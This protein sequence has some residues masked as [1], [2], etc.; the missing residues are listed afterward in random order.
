MGI[1]FVLLLVLFSHSLSGEY[2]VRTEDPYGV[3][4]KVLK[5]IDKN[6]YLVEIEDSLLSGLRT[7]AEG[8]LIEKNYT[9]R[10]L[11]TPN[12]PCLSERW[13]LN[14][15]RAYEAWDT[16]TGSADVYVV[17]LDTGVDYNHPDLK[18]NLW[19]NPGEVCGDGSDDDNNGY[20]DDCY[21]I[22]ALCYPSGTYD[23]NAPGCN[24][25]DALD[26][27]GH[28]TAVASVIGAVGNNATL[29]AGVNWRVKIIPCKFLDSTGMGEIDGEIECLNY[30]LELKRKGLNIVAVNASYGDVYPD[31]Q[32]QKDKILELAQEGIMYIA[33][34]GNENANN[35]LISMNP[36]NYDFDN[37]LC[38][39]AVN[40]Q[41][42]RS[43][44]S[45][46]GFN[47]VKISAPG[48]NASEPQEAIMSLGMGKYDNMCSSLVP[49]AGTSLATPFVTGAVALLKSYQPGLSYD[50]VRERILTSGRNDP[51]LAGQTYTCNVLD[52]SSMLSGDNTP[53]VC[54]SSLYLSWGEVEG[55]QTTEREFVVRNTGGGDVQVVRVYTDGSGFYVSKDECSGRQL[56]TFQECR[57]YVAFSPTSR[58]SY[59][60][61][62][63]VSFSNSGLNLTVSL[64]ADSVSG[65]GSSG[66]C[67]SAAPLYGYLLLLAF[68][69]RLAR[70]RS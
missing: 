30:V 70:V 2:L 49:T 61:K 1:L 65:C 15:I 18:D 64:Y 39:G 50:Q 32:I 19:K 59:S 40:S 43:D 57:I 45:N 11:Q 44:F 68:L 66:G 33:A 67:N 8:V 63:F 35:D 53:K 42:H 48:G 3:P 26:D 34:A 46:Y 69:L 13:D 28:G 36:C 27:N 12:D 6:T 17:V 14:L 10:A 7:N 60:G 29:T 41:G 54:A 25:P 24:S 58:G 31:S 38:V 62:L 20:V 56:K 4:G 55:C 47:K 22:N 16:A 37:M 51:S 23:S 52:L 9:L 5:R 21:G